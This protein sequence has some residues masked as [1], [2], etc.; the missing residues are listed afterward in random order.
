MKSETDK[1]G[2]TF[3]QTSITAVK[4]AKRA[5]LFLAIPDSRFTP[6]RA[7]CCEVYFSTW[8][9]SPTYRITSQT[10]RNKQKVGPLQTSARA[11]GITGYLVQ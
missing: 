4:E 3:L 10:T 2:P 11:E 8:R 6:H 9:R 5:Y 1:F 7:Y